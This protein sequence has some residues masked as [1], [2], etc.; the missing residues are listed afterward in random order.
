MVIH[1]FSSTELEEVNELINTF[2]TFRWSKVRY[3]PYRDRLRVKGQ[4][5]DGFTEEDIREM[6]EI[7][8]ENL[9]FNIEAVAYLLNCP[10]SVLP[11]YVG[12][13]DS[14]YRSLI[15][16]RLKIGK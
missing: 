12:T 15:E 4:G 14:E 6:G 1:T 3:Y 16:Y 10:L 8:L 5:I 2:G 11:L 13:S 7:G 9:Q